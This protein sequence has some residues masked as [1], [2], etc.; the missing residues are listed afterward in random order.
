MPPLV[1]PARN[2]TRVLPLPL[3]QQPSPIA[4]SDWGP[5]P[6]ERIWH[7]RTETE[8]R[9]DYRLKWDQADRTR[10][11]PVE[12]AFGLVV[13]EDGSPGRGG[14]AADLQELVTSM[15]AAVWGVEAAAGAPGWGRQSCKGLAAIKSFALGSAFR[16]GASGP[17]LNPGGPRPPSRDAFRHRTKG[18]SRVR[19]AATCRPSVLLRRTELATLIAADCRYAEGTGCGSLCLPW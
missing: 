11:A 16:W 4:R 6:G 15:A 19:T 18:R 3:I 17:A 8:V 13:P 9:V 7:S 12:R 14:L 1:V 5:Q 2:L 10:F